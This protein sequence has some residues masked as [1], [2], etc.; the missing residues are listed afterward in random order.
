M[1][2]SS[3]PST[4]PPP[5]PWTPLAR[6]SRALRRLCCLATRALALSLRAVTS[7]CALEHAL[8]AVDAALA[9]LAGQLV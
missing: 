4:G 8:P 3:S 7:A 5:A 2:I 6:D 1:S 9:E